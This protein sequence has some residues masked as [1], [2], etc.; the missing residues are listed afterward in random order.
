MD[1]FIEVSNCDKSTG[2][3]FLM[4]ALQKRDIKWKLALKNYH[5]WD[6]AVLKLNSRL[7]FLP[8]FTGG[9]KCL[10]SSLVFKF[11]GGVP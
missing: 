1:N 2:L 10:E 8:L 7:S 3:E 11:C 5:I 9:K 4:I 6:L